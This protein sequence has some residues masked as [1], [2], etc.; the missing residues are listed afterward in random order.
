MSATTL[1]NLTSTRN[2]QRCRRRVVTFSSRVPS[3]SIPIRVPRGAIHRTH[4]EVQLEHDEKVARWRDAEMYSRLLHGMATRGNEVGYHPDTGKAIQRIMYTKRTPVP[5][6]TS[7]CDE[8]HDWIFS[9]VSYE[10]EEERHSYAKR[11]EDKHKKKVTFGSLSSSY[12]HFCPTLSSSGGC[13]DVVSDMKNFQ[14]EECIF[15][16]E[17]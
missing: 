10:V 4:S 14:D 3:P 15:D 5:P 8:D 11:T 12:V 6:S 17:L 9:D 2:T 7:I 16:I 1:N 13:C